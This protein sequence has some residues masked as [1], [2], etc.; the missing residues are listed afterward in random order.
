M[1]VTEQL[2]RFYGPL[3]NKLGKFAVSPCT[4]AY[5]FSLQVEDNILKE[6]FVPSDSL[7]DH[8][9]SMGICVA[10]S[11]FPV[12]PAFLALTA[13]MA[14]LTTIVALAAALI[15]YP[16]VIATDVVSYIACDL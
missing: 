2:N 9:I 14:I 7:T 11:V 16:V 6:K 3:L 10:L 15:A 4:L 5:Q 12:L 13:S 8:P 1:S